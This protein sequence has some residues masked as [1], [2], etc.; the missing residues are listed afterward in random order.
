M[1]GQNNDNPNDNA[2]SG[3]TDQNF[4]HPGTPIDDAAISTEPTEQAAPPVE[5]QPQSTPTLPQTPV[6]PTTDLA[7][8]SS[9]D[10]IDIKQKA[11]SQLSPLMDHLDQSPEDKFRT[12]MMMIQATDDQ[13]LINKAYSAAQEI[14]DEKIRAQAFFDVVNEINYFTQQ[15]NPS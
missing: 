2:A 3:A 7:D 9:N 5:S 11:L 12:I 10:L 4:Q 14:A 8:T 15:Q 1:F 13:T 6:E